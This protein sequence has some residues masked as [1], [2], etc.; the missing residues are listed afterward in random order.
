MTLASDINADLTAI[1]GDWS[2]SITITAV[3]YDG[4]FDTELAE[5]LDFAGYSPV[6]SMLTS[7]ATASGLARGQTVQVTSAISGISNKNYTV[8]VV[9]PSIDGITR[10]VLSE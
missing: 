2:D 10:L 1:M 8:R 5:S 4:L 7:D 6:F 9:D 3:N